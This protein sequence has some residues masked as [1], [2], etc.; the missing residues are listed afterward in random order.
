MDNPV[1]LA[2]GRLHNR[3]KD[4]LD[5]FDQA[6][7]TFGHAG[8][9][10]AAGKA[11]HTVM[12]EVARVAREGYFE[13]VSEDCPPAKPMSMEA[14]ARI[15]RRNKLYDSPKFVEMRRN[16][17]LMSRNGADLIKQTGFGRV[18][19]T[20][21]VELGMKGVMGLLFQLNRQEAEADIDPMFGDMVSE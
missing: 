17:D 9:S 11:W 5:L 19:Y 6:K 4:M 8:P 16:V 20:E 18:D 10:W 3:A 1:Y 14:A 2:N 7:E 15:L 13:A 21:M 12:I